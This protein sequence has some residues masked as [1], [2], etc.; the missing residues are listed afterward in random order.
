MKLTVCIPCYNAMPHLPEAV[1][2]VLSQSWSRFQLIIIDDGSVDDTPAYLKSIA[3]ND[4]RISILRQQ[5]RG[6]GATLN[7]SLALC[8]TELYARMDADDVCM[9]E[10]F[11][12]Q[13]H[14]L[15]RHPDVV[16][17]GTHYR[18][19]TDRG[20][21]PGMSVP[22]DHTAILQRISRG[23]AGLCHPSLML[24]SR[25]AAQ[26]GGYTIPGAGQDFDFFLR[27]SEQGQLANLPDILLG[28]RI[29]PA[30]TSFRRRDAVRCGAAYAVAARKCR[31]A[32]TAE[33]VYGK[34]SSDWLQQRTFAKRGMDRLED[35]S[36]ETYR[37]G[38]VSRCAGKHV[39][40]WLLISVAAL[41]RPR[42][43][44]WHVSQFLRRRMR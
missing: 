11:A 35:F 1:D 39:R 38:L 23:K 9:P 27:M 40:A 26:I 6:L 13:I 44:F 33:P 12:K 7:R 24:R 4:P 28:Y 10:R 22:Q 25:V 18:F 21:S 16:M 2:S 20:S 3:G 19:L 30:S 42:D 17:V 31:Q 37:R 8:E 14:F 34:F 43:L 41:L 36:F 32:G 5:N 15:Q 29:S